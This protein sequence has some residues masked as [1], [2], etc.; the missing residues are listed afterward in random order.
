MRHLFDLTACV[1]RLEESA[2]IVHIESELHPVHEAAGAAMLFSGNEPV[3]CE[4]IV[5]SA[6][7]VFGGLYWNRTL[8]ASLFGCSPMDLSQRIVEAIEAW[9]SDPVDPIVVA[10]GPANEVVEDSVDLHRLPILTHALAD[11][12]P[13]IDAAVVVARD[14]DTGVRNASIIRAMVTGPDRLTLQLNPGGHLRA[15]YERASA[16]G[17]RLQVTIN[18]GV[19]PAVHFAAIVPQSVADVNSDELGVASHF[20][21]EPLPLVESRAVAVEGIADAQFILEAELLPEVREPEG[22]FAEMT[23]HYAAR[24]DRWVARVLRI[25]RRKQ[26]LWHTIFPGKETSNSMA[27]MREAFVYREV[28]RQVPEVMAVHFTHGGCG[29]FHAVVQLRAQQPAG[30]AKNAILSTFAAYNG[31]K[32][33]V[34]VDEDVDP[35]DPEDVEW[36]LAV[37]FRPEQDLILIPN[38]RGHFMN[39]STDDGLGTKIGIDA[40]AAAPEVAE[41]RR[42]VAVAKVERGQLKIRRGR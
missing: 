33:V 38:A 31:L 19:G 37:R 20:V 36:A 17:E 16:R 15:Y 3:V 6:F 35:L 8:L 10:D 18:N 1:A 13:Y 42:R 26:P 9:Q 29:A 2:Q 41:K 12:G 34:A 22:P 25:T 21:G 39:P 5:G 24:A 30:A 7:P 23:G 40:T 32:M 4:S 28:K 14:P 27:L 11:G